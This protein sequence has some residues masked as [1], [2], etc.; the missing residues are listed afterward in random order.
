M[1]GNARSDLD[2]AR[3]YSLHMK[4]CQVGSG[5]DKSLVLALEALQLFGVTFP[6]PTM[7]ISGS[8]GRGVSNR[9]RQPG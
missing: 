6:N 3:I 4:V 1:L 7:K 5:Y 9:I 8:R 2:R